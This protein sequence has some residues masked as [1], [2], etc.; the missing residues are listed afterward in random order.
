LAVE[1]Y[2]ALRNPGS[3]RVFLPNGACLYLD[4]GGHPEFCTP[5]CADPKDLVRYVL[6][7]DVILWTL[8]EDLI[9]SGSQAAEVLVFRSNVDY[10]AGTTWGAHESYLHRADPKRLPDDIIPHLVS[11]IVFAGAGGFRPGGRLRELT[12]SPRAWLLE[13]AVS[14]SSTEARGIFHT[15]DEPLCKGGYHRLHLLCG[16]SLCSHRA[17]WLKAGTTALVVAMA[18]AGLQPGRDVA[19]GTP[20]SSLRAFAADPRCRARTRC[21]RGRLTAIEIQRHYLRLAET[22]LGRHFM[23]SWAAEVCRAWHD[24]LEEL[25]GAPESVATS[26]DW[27]I[28]WATYPHPGRP[29]APS[30]RPGREELYELET[31]YSQLG[32]EGIFARLDG[33]GVLRHRVPGI[34]RVEEAVCTPPPSGRAAARG[35]WV[36]KLGAAGSRYACDWSCVYDLGENRMID[37]GHPFENGEEWQPCSPDHETVARRDATFEAIFGRHRRRMLLAQLRRAME[38]PR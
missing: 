7:G 21:A 26:L 25:S 20:L 5:E 32:G 12:L 23:P 15:K 13:H 31:R 11:R 33:K 24:V 30:R 9:R 6:A 29:V 18:E 16:E 22:H 17:A 4:V 8:A 37:L 38:A 14:G 34:D 28:K 2:A 3:N 1:K 10:V 27:A 35:A 19:M 36:R